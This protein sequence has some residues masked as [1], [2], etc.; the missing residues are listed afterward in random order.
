MPIESSLETPTGMHP[1][2][3]P[4]EYSAAYEQGYSHTRRFI[5]SRG[6]P[7]DQAAEIAQAAWV[8]GWAHRQ[9]AYN[10]QKVGLWVNTIALNLL[11]GSFRRAPTTE[12]HGNVGIVRPISVQT[13]DYRRV[14]GQC[15]PADRKLLEGFYMGGYTSAQLGKLY[16][17]TAVA[18]RV[19]LFRLRQ[20]LQATLA[21]SRSNRGLIS[22]L[23]RPEHRTKTRDHI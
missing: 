2:M 21:A 1:T 15:S 13:I 6:V 9:Q 12:L 11:R 14:L 19:R 20:H 22:L 16:G 4:E 5:A 23:P 18:V 8:K 10:I 7:L 17:L 3:T